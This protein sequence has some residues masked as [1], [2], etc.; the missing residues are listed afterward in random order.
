MSICTALLKPAE[1]VNIKEDHLTL[2]T[3]QFPL[4]V[5]FKDNAGKL[6]EELLDYQ[7]ANETRLPK[8]IREN[9]KHRR[10][11]QYC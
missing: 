6:Q 11:H 5:I 3:S 10:I 8:E 9:D 4:L 2:L 7:T 1:L